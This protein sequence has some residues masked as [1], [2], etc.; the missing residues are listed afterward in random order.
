MEYVIL[1]IDM[2]WQIIN[3]MNHYHK[4]KESSNIIYGDYNNLYEETMSQKLPADGFKWVEDLSV[5]GEDFIKNHDEDSDVGYFIKADIVYPKKL[6]IL[7]SD[8]PFFPERMEVIKC[9]S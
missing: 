1:Y 8:L 6:H 4:N 9:K 5:I 7:H 2:L 3:I